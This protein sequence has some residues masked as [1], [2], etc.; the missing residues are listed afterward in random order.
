MADSLTW[1]RMSLVLVYIEILIGVI[2]ALEA[3]YVLSLVRVIV[4]LYG[5]GTRCSPE[6][7]SNSKNTI[8]SNRTVVYLKKVCR[9]L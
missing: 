3:G 6:T 2:G 8:F 7:S 1:K 4:Q 9:D 5:G